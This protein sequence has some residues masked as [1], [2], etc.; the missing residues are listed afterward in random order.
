MS[1]SSRSS[2]SV[3]V[4]RGLCNMRI[5]ASNGTLVSNDS[6]SP[7]RSRGVSPLSDSMMSE[8]GND[9]FNKDVI[10]HEMPHD[11]QGESGTS[12]EIHVDDLQRTLGEIL[13]YCQ[14]TY[15]A[16]LKL[17]E[18]FDMLQAKV[19]N[20]QTLHQN[21]S[22]LLSQKTRVSSGDPDSFQKT[23]TPTSNLSIPHLPRIS[24]SLSVG[25]RKL[26]TLSPGPEVNRPLRLDIQNQP[27]NS[28][29]H[30]SL[31]INRTKQKQGRV[32][33]STRIR[34]DSTDPAKRT[35]PAH[36]CKF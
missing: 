20:I 21:P 13:G 3:Q 29:Q 34:T 27:H 1:D 19:A 9:G 17:E 25:S 15:G 33:G 14:V 31:N 23:R 5:E 6:T 11:S 16:I 4:S 12:T 35:T 22:A 8:E 32:N 24:S 36:S 7:V 26:P 18:K 28:S 2:M 30:L 10:T